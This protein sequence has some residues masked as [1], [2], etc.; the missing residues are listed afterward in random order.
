MPL[1][2]LTKMISYTHTHQKKKKKKPHQ[3]Y[4]LPKKREVLK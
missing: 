3:N 4:L 2:L 1:K